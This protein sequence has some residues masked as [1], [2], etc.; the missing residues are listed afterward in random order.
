MSTDPRVVLGL[1]AYNQSEH[2]D[3]AVQT[4]LA[5]RYADFAIIAIDDHSDDGTHERL[6]HY[7]DLDDRLI[8]VSRN[9]RRLGMV[10]NFN[11][12]LRVARELR[13]GRRVLRMG[14]RPRYLAPV[15]VGVS[16]GRT[17]GRCSS[18]ARL[19]ELLESLR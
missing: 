9:S 5:Q 17:G 1:P 8:H 14:E 10:A 19:P 6:L 13:P 11:R 15:L 2:L 16:G 3:E 7:A 18:R 12:T 4:L